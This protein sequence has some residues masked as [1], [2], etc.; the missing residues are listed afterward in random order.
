VTYQELGRLAREV[1]THI[2]ML[3][4]CQGPSDAPIAA[5][6]KERIDRDWRAIAE[7]YPPADA[8]APE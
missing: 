6:L 4:Q 7:S 1:A 5:K 2:G 8:G 3:A